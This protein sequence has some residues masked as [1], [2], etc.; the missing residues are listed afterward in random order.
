MPA[1]RT[2]AAPDRRVHV[3][4]PFDWN[5]AGGTDYWL[6]F[7]TEALTSAAGRLLSDQGWTGVVATF[8]ETAG[9]AADFISTSDRG[10]PAHLLT[11]GSGDIL[12]SPAVFGD[13]GHA[14]IAAA[15][16]GYQPTRLVCEFYAAMTV[17]TANETRSGWG[18][19]VAGGAA[20]TDADRL[21]WISTDATNFNISSS[22]DS[23]AGALD[24]ALWTMFKIV[25]SNAVAAGTDMVEW[26]INGTSQGTMDLLTDVFPCSFGMAALTTNRPGLAMVHV[27]YE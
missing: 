10:A 22:A 25:V 18:L 19:I 12:Q 16:L 6:V 26:F 27:Y 1:L 15:I 21:A 7:G 23:D 2:T 5:R 3:T 20:G 17:H 14:Q 24:D 8:T 9:S 13:Y 4:D 11:N